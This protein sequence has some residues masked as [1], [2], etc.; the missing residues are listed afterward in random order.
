MEI[1]W[2]REWWP[3]IAFGIATALAAAAWAVR[4]GLASK[5][6]LAAAERVWGQAVGQI[7]AE[8]QDQSERLSKVETNIEHLPTVEDINDVKERLA[9]VGG[10][11]EAMQA[12]QQVQGKTLERIENYLLTSRGGA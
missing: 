8:L 5:D 3:V 6:D 1:N 4:K 7:K 2:V 11:V 12:L 10:R 9:R